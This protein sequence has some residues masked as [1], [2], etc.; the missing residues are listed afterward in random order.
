MRT[1]IRLLIGLL[2]LA[3][4]VFLLVEY[5]ELS[6]AYARHRSGFWDL[7][8]LEKALVLAGPGGW[9]GLLLVCWRISVPLQMIEL[10]L[11]F[12]LGTAG[13]LVS[14][15]CLNPSDIGLFTFVLLA[16]IWILNSLGGLWL[17]RTCRQLRVQANCR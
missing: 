15:L 13:G 11:V 1:R 9:A 6:A 16:G 12:F 17:W 4:L 10:A 5:A 7:S 2:S 8:S 3:A 14:T